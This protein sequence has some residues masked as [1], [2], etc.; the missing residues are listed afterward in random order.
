[1]ESSEHLRIAAFAQRLG[2]ELVVTPLDG[3]KAQLVVGLGQP[4][5][6]LSPRLIDPTELRWAIA[7]ELGH[8]VL[9][10]PSPPAK[11]LGLPR[12][13][14]RR[15]NRRDYE[16]EA[17]GFASAL[18]FQDRIAASICDT[19]PMTF[20]VV[21]RL[22][23]LC[24]APWWVSAIHLTQVTWRVCAIIVSQ[25]GV[26]SSVWPSLPFLM[27]CGGRI[28]PDQPIGPGALARRFFDTGTPCGLPELVPASAWLTGCGPELR[29]QEH[30]IACPEL[31]AVITMLWD[32][33]ESDTPRPPEAT[34]RAVA[35]CLDYL[36]V[37][38]EES[39]TLSQIR[40]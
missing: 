31:G 33:A 36:L 28:W 34:L 10:H 12:R 40:A 9:G 14:R 35:I 29:L 17:N 7:H 11:E 16:A 32:P 1:V 5:I 23:E 39:Q 25:G 8:F 2:I 27:L 18:L 37:E 13:R 21:G 4:H 15:R 30:S 38:L 19:R 20:D 3:A 6:L 22:A 24:A 26:I